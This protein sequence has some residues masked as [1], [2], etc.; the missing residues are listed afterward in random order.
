MTFY[1]K[2]TNTATGRVGYVG[3]LCTKTG[4]ERERDAW[5]DSEGR[6]TADVL[7]GTPEV[8]AAVKQWQR[9]A[10]IRHGRRPRTRLNRTRI[11]PAH[12]RAPS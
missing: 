9:D 12:E 6:F 3:P 11:R 1:V 7:P 2:R 5:N 8:R 10:D 4:A